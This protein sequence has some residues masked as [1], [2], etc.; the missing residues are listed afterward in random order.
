[1]KILFQSDDYGITR[2]VSLGCIRGIEAGVIRNTGMF[3]NMPWIEE[4]VSWIE[5]HLGKI[6]LGIDLN[7]STGPSVLGHGEVPA[8]THADGTF[9]GSRENRALDTEENGRDHLA[10][11]A[12]QLEAEFRA[13]IERYIELGGHK[14]DYIHNHAYGT[15][16]TREVTFKLACEYG[17]LWSESLMARPEVKAAGMGWY[18]FGGGP[19]AQLTEDPLGFFTQDKDGLLASGK[20]WGYVVSHCGYADAELFKLTSFNTCRVKDLEC[21]CSPELAAWMGEN[22]IEP[23]S[24]KD[25]PRAWVTEQ[26]ANPMP[27]APAFMM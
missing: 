17:A 18:V 23:V 27:A 11:V 22:G 4:C 25:V 10:A 6:A 13:Q 24:F 5:P 8:L 1:M 16:T 14:P 20:E 15:A 2:A 12:D 7:A 26:A 19:E 3:A 9:L 21:M